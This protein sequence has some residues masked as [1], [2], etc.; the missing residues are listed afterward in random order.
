MG[1]VAWAL[2][3]LLVA[4]GASAQS[5]EPEPEPE[6]APPEPEPEPEPHYEMLELH[7]GS[8]FFTHYNF[9]QWTKDRSTHGVASC[10][11]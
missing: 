5:P 3:L 7:S 10:V 2:V 1:G 4:I 6:P 11:R 8:N 9:V